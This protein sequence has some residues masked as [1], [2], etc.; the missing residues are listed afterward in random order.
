MLVQG[1]IAFHFS[2]NLNVFQEL[3]VFANLYSH[4]CFFHQDLS[5]KF[6]VVVPCAREPIPISGP[7][8]VPVLTFVP[9]RV[10]R[11]MTS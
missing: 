6:G 10:A 9:L 4:T 7:H 5:R 1:Q 11:I 8:K 3:N 2:G